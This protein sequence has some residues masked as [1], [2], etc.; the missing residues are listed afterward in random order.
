MEHP[1]TKPEPAELPGTEE[2]TE[3]QGITELL[4]EDFDA[5]MPGQSM[6]PLL[7]AMLALC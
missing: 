5:E 2:H 1:D 7:R 6:D 4:L 3:L